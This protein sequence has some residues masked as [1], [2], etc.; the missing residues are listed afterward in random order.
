[1]IVVLHLDH[2]VCYSFFGHLVFDHTLNPSVN[3]RE[4]EKVIDLQL[5]LPPLL[6]T[7]VIS[8]AD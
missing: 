4:E 5:L 2:S 6:L 8:S 7:C 1:M 3:L